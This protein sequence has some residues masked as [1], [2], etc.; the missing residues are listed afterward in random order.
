MRYCKQFPGPLWLGLLLLPLSVSSTPGFFTVWFSTVSASFWT[1]SRISIIHLLLSDERALAVFRM[2]DPPSRSA[3]RLR[4]LQLVHTAYVLTLI[5]NC[6]LNYP[7][8]HSC[9]L[10]GSYSRDI[11]MNLCYS[12]TAYWDYRSWDGDSRWR[13]L[14]L[15]ISFSL[16]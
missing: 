3:G 11:L 8:K 14:V 7:R 12:H 1:I 10:G 4:I 6:I 13:S 5:Y 15:D 16:V 2:R 9:T